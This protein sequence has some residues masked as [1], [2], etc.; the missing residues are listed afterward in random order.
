MI[1]IKNFFK[2]LPLNRDC[3]FFEDILQQKGFKLE[4]IISFGQN[5]PEN[6]WY[7]Q[8]QEE[9]VILLKGSATLVFED[10]PGEIELNP[11]D[12][13]LIKAHQKHRVSRTD[14]DQPSFW[15]AIH[16]DTV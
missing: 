4:R 3:E 6:E 13:L 1:Q 7:D 2:E 10:K 11:G 9:W 12:H 14:P 15:L 8:E 5:T 16:F